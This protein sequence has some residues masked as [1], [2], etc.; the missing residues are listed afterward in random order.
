[1]APDPGLA[2]GGWD[3][4]RAAVTALAAAGIETILDVVL[5][6]SGEGD[7]LGPDPVAA[8]AGQRDLLPPSRPG[9]PW[10]YVDDTGCGNTIA[11]DRPAPLAPGHGRASG[12]GHASWRARLPFRSRDNAGR[13]PE[14][15]DPAAPLLSA[16]AQ[17]PVL[18]NLKLIA[19][20]WDVGPGGYQLGAFPASW[21]EWN[22]RFRDGVRRFWRGDGGQSR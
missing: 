7:A 20:P 19:E 5:N 12:L 6:H 11:L 16:I 13:R 17:D 10:R 15:F 4:I 22:D 18:R 2:P 1:M 21:G 8:R 14:G 9:T 3:E